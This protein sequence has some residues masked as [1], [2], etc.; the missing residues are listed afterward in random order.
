[1]KNCITFVIFFSFCVFSCKQQENIQITARYNDVRIT[2]E[3][4]YPKLNFNLLEGINYRSYG[5]IELTNVG[6]NVIE[7]FFVDIESSDVYF[8]CGNHNLAVMRYVNEYIQP[9]ET[10]KMFVRW[11]LKKGKIQNFEKKNITLLVRPYIL[12]DELDPSVV[13]FSIR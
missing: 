4:P 13:V 8:R 1:M 6:S 7:K 3:L 9:G 10:V 2:V 12:G 5:T 11:D